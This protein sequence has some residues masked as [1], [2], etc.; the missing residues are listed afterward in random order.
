MK[1]FVTGGTGQLG[2]EVVRQL[3]AAG[4]E[5]VALVRNP[6]RARLLD[7][8]PC[9][10]LQGDV[11]QPESLQISGCE[12]VFHL[13]GVVSYWKPGRPRLDR[14][15]V[16]GTANVLHA[17]VA[18]G[19]R[20]FV[21]TSSIATLGHVPGHDVGD[22]DSPFNWGPWNLGYQ[23]TKLAAERLV[24][25]ETRI[26]TLAVLP[27]I[28]FGARDAQQNGGRMLLQVTQGIPGVPCGATTAANLDDV[29]AG[30][31]LALER[32]RPGRR[33]VLGG[34]TGS[35]RD[36]FGRVAQVLGA[37]APT[38]VLPEPIL[39][40]NGLWQEL[41]GRLS[42]Q[43]PKYTRELARV[44]ARNRQYSSDRAMRELGYA[45]RPLEIGI[46]ACREWYR[47]EGLL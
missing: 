9:T 38:R 2:S 31:L 26:D 5:V 46:E 15:N 14:V 39:L 20:R 36:L 37:P 40:A 23:E 16:S 27:G 32:G 45:P 30:H 7:G 13:A 33:Y 24:L 28:V 47:A 17:A 12:V 22:E 29:A 3:V 8:V 43:E 34:T 10:L 11:T 44:T 42:G 6:D 35:F 41:R 25:A 21:L 18:A 1:V 4:H 19:V